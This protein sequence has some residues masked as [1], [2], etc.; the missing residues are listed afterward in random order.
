MSTGRAPT[1]GFVD[2][3]GRA[4]RI[5][6]GTDDEPDGS[7]PEHFVVED[8]VRLTHCGRDGSAQ[9]EPAYVV[10]AHSSRSAPAC[11]GY[12]VDVEVLC[13]VD[14]HCAVGSGRCRR[15]AL[16]PAAVGSNT[17]HLSVTNA[18]GE[19]AKPEDSLSA[20]DTSDRSVHSR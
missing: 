2:R 20:I 16:E 12:K 7:D 13:L 3:M 8:F 1:Q 15:N 9:L 14:D 19:I 10:S 4:I 18:G 5:L 6:N 17:V 11:F